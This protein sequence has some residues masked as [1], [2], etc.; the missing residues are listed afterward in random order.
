MGCPHGQQTAFFLPRHGF[1]DA[2]NIR[3]L[4]RLLSKVYLWDPLHPLTDAS[5]MHP[6]HAWASAPTFEA[7]PLRRA[8]PL[9]ILIHSRL[10]CRTENPDQRNRSPAPDTSGLPSSHRGH[11]F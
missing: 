3:L 10:S 2:K 6:I 5:M 4:L 11:P 8:P 9:I 7:E 1:L